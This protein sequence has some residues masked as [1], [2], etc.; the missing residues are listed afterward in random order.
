MTER[1][2]VAASYSQPTPRRLYVHDDLTEEVRRRLGPDSPA[3]A[4]GQ[5]LLDL[6]R[7]DEDRVV[8]LTV[9]DQLDRLVAQ[10]AHVPYEL[11]LGLARAGERV[12]SQMHARTGWFP[13]VRRID[14]AREEDGRGGY[15]LI[16]TVAASL[17]DQLGGLESCRSLAV[18]DDTVFSGLTMRGIL[19]ALPP[20]LLARTRAFCLRGVAETLA[21]VATLC[22]ITAGVAA[23]GMLLS[24]ISFINATGLVLRVAIRRRGQEPLAFFDRPEWLRAWFPGYDREVLELCRRLNALLEPSSGAATEDATSPGRSNSRS[25]MP[26]GP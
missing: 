1:R 14:I 5:R 8:V 26:Y 25:A 3:V 13:R 15:T 16:S 23:P 9:E 10:G 18:V 2:A 12:A 22:P 7:Q 20:G 19:G 21:A 17:E 4:L 6:L 24:E 11:T